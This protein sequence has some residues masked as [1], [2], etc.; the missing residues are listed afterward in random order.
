MDRSQFKR[1]FNVCGKLGGIILII[2]LEEVASHFV[3]AGIPDNC[4]G[5]TTPTVSWNAR[6]F[7][8]LL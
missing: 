5:L 1:Y 4:F 3:I 2:G 7:V 8:Y 6:P